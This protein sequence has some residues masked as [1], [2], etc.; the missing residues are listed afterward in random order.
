MA[1]RGGCARAGARAG[2]GPLVSEAARMKTWVLLRGLTREAGHWGGFARAFEA[3]VEPQAR[4]I[5]LDLP[6]AGR[7]HEMR[8]PWRVDQAMR[9][10][11]EQL[12]AQ[13][14]T[15]PVRLFGLSL[16]GMVAAAWALAHPDDVSHLVLVNSSM[17]PLGAPHERLRIG[18]WPQVLRAFAARDA[19]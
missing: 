11:R 2:A 15:E 9:F 13:G 16:G 1:A 10:C 18:A 3:G 19:R 5:T 6:G 4:V 17:R 14:G 7:W 8:S 12:R